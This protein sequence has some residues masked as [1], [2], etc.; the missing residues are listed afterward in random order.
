MGVAWRRQQVHAKRRTSGIILL[1]LLLWLF[2]TIAGPF[3]ALVASGSGEADTVLLKETSCGFFEVTQPDDTSNFYS[4]QKQSNDSRTARQYS[5][6]CYGKN[7]G[8]L[9]CTLLPVQHLPYDIKL[10]AACPFRGVNRCV[11]GANGAIALDTGFLDSHDHLGI[12]TKSKDR[13]QFRKVM[14]CAVIHT[15]DNE[16]SLQADSLTGGKTQIAYWLLGPIQ[17][18][19]NYT[20]SYAARNVGSNIGY[21]VK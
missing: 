5:S 2:F 13:I 8:T 15:S 20:F 16:I 6:N 1:P 12:N 9:A 18:V 14:S 17:G 21:T 3:S 10:D 7:R 11:T 4:A 19:S